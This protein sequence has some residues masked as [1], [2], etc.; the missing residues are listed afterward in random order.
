MDD[1]TSVLRD[2]FYAAGLSRLASSSRGGMGTSA[3]PPRRHGTKGAKHT[4]IRTTKGRQAYGGKAAAVRGASSTAVPSAT[5][6]VRGPALLRRRQPTPGR[7]FGLPHT[8]TAAPRD[9]ADGGRADADA[10]R[11]GLGGPSSS[12]SSSSSTAAGTIPTMAAG[13]ATRKPRPPPQQQ[14]GYRS[15][16]GGVAGTR[17]LLEPRQKLGYRNANDDGTRVLDMETPGLLPPPSRTPSLSPTTPRTAATTEAMLPEDWRHMDEAEQYRAHQLAAYEKEQREALHPL[18]RDPPPGSLFARLSLDP[19][20]D[21]R[22]LEQDG[23]LY[24]AMRPPRTVDVEVDEGV[25]DNNHNDQAAGGPG[26]EADTDADAAAAAS[27]GQGWRAKQQR[28]RRVAL[29]RGGRR[30]RKNVVTKVIATS[31]PFDLVIMSH[32]AVKEAKPRR[33]FV[34]SKVGVTMYTYD[35]LNAH[36]GSSASAN[37]RSPRSRKAMEKKPAFVTAS[38]PRSSSSSSSSASSSGRGPIATADTSSTTI[39]GVGTP[40]VEYMTLEHFEQGY[41]YHSKIMEIPFFRLYRKWKSLRT[42]RTIVKRRKMRTAKRLLRRRLFLLDPVLR[43]SLLRVRVFVSKVASYSLFRCDSLPVGGSVTA[44]AAAAATSEAGDGDTDSKEDENGAAA[45]DQTETAAKKKRASLDQQTSGGV[46]GPLKLD[47]FHARQVAQRRDVQRSLDTFQRR[48]RK[49]VA[50]TCDLSLD[51]FLVASGF[52]HVETDDEDLGNKDE[53]KTETAAGG[54]IVVDSAAAAAAATTAAQYR[55][56]FTERATM[57]T[58][59]RRLTRFIRLVDFTVVDTF[60]EIALLSTIRLLEYVEPQAKAKEEEEE[61]EAE[62]EEGQEQE[63]A[64]DEPAPGGTTADENVDEATAAAAAAA[65]LLLDIP[66]FEIRICFD[67]E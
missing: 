22:R 51:S 23:F 61:E 57:R 39:V 2:R 9:G 20:W 60:L 56:T 59:C 46:S 31:D 6:A 34:L 63:T 42:W 4:S 29:G 45:E 62:E 50:E 27:G 8:S 55:I 43:E 35:T 7:A 16:G 1:K 15:R 30:R 41:S 5:G 54:A 28:E 18:L 14:Q 32:R 11:R 58:Q 36:A 3:G 13:G 49:V 38:S 67:G 24:L 17:A 33:F 25:D 19:H 37:G 47:E 10:G 53:E 26:D 64:G 12:S 52:G 66:L 48:V 65:K 44:A 21:L 40:E